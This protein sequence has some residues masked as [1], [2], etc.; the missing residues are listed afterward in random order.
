MTTKKREKNMLAALHALAEKLN[1]KI[2]K[3]EI[4]GDVMLGLDE[5]KRIAYYHKHQKENSRSESV[6]LNEMS[7]CKLLSQVKQIKSTNQNF[8]PY[9]RLG[10]EF[11]SKSKNEPN[12]V[13]VFYNI[14]D[15]SYLNIDVKQLEKWEQLLNVEI[16]KR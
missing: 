9:E 12:V 11:V 6:L 3:K 8:N 7:E 15:S 1:S 10:L 14:D 16:K 2:N 5:K 13:W 4:I